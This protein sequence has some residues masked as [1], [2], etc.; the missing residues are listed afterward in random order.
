MTKKKKWI[1]WF[2]VGVYLLIM[3]FLAVLTIIHFVNFSKPV[4]V[5]KVEVSGMDV[6]STPID[7]TM[8]IGEFCRHLRQ[9]FDLAVDSVFKKNPDFNPRCRATV[10]FRLDDGLMTVFTDA[11]IQPCNEC[12]TSELVRAN[13]IQDPVE[14]RFLF[15]GHSFVTRRGMTPEEY[16]TFISKKGGQTEIGFLG[17]N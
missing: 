9:G 8:T 14:G 5:P 12:D 1:R 11:F 4:Y 10:Y 3:H 16:L 6:Q 13:I 15:D 2:P 7:S 17:G